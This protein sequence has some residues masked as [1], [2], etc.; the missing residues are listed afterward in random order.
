MGKFDDVLARVIERKT[1]QIT[2]YLETRF[3]MPPEKEH[4]KAMIEQALAPLA[5]GDVESY[6]AQRAAFDQMH[7]AAKWRV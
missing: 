5:E 7:G 3:D 6:E 1:E 4:I 2:K